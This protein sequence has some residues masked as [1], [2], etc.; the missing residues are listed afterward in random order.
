MVLVVDSMQAAITDRFIFSNII[1]FDN[2]Y[3]I[4]PSPGC[5]EFLT[6]FIFSHLTIYRV[7]GGD[8]IS[9]SL[10]GQ[11]FSSDEQVRKVLLT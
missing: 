8:C 2:K 5:T 4:G 1:S 10:K 3:D 7:S 9:T 11:P 6:E